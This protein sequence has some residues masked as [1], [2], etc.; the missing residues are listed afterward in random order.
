MAEPIS[1]AAAEFGARV[2]A[3]RYELGISQEKLADNCGL[4]WT[5][6]GQVERGQRNLALHNILKLA[7]GL[8]IDPCELVK[9]L[10]V[11]P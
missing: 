6:V 7:A 9:H 2:R 10:P 1:Q 3:R 8:G 11:P 5:F 4:H